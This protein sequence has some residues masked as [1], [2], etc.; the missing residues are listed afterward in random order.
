M[1][2]SQGVEQQLKSAALPDFASTPLSTAIASRCTRQQEEAAEAVSEALHQCRSAAASWQRLSTQLA[3]AEAWLSAAEADQLPL[4][5]AAEQLLQQQRALGSC[6]SLLHS[7]TADGHVASPATAQLRRQAT[8]VGQRLDALAEKQD[9]P[10]QR[11]LL[12][13]QQQRRLARIH[14]VATARPADGGAAL[15]QRLAVELAS[16]T[17]LAS[18]LRH[19]SVTASTAPLRAEAAL[20]LQVS[21]AGGPPMVFLDKLSVSLL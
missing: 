15:P 19:L 3:A 13:A 4:Q 5:E 16:L 14:S 11:T 12:V 9:E 8:L 6:V 10:P 7:L 21:G 17:D 20:L 1:F 2:F 18:E